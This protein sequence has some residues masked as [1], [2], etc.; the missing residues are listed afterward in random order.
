[1]KLE[2]GLHDCNIARIIILL[3][4][5]LLTS[6]YAFSFVELIKESLEYIFNEKQSI[7]IEGLKSL[8][9]LTYS[10]HVIQEEYDKEYNAVRK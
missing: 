7:A 6:V 4:S 2:L 9:I 8:F 10:V 3:L 5:L 1:M